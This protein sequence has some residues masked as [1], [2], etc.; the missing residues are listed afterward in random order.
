MQ[1]GINRLKDKFTDVKFEIT[2]IGERLRAE[3]GIS[4]NEIINNDPD[5]KYNREASKLRSTTSNAASTTTA[6]ST[7]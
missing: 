1:G 3:F 6:R 5:P 4:V 7:P 2:A